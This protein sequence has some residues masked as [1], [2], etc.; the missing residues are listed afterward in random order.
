MQKNYLIRVVA[1][2]HGEVAE[3]HGSRGLVDEAGLRRHIVALRVHPSF[4]ASLSVKI[5]GKTMS[6]LD[7][8]WIPTSWLVK[9]MGPRLRDPA[10]WL[11]LAA[12]M[13]SHNLG[14]L[15]LTIRVAMQGT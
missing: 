1:A 8:Y 6:F 13:C 5:T 9:T 2:V 3:R 15:F 7:S 10:L 11:P 12:G 4:N 14:P